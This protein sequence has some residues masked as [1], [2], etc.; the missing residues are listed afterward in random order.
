MLHLQFLVATE[1]I[2]YS[3]LNYTLDFFPATDI[4][5]HFNFAIFAVQGASG[6][7]G[8]AGSPGAD[9]APGERGDQGL[10]GGKG[11]KGFKVWRHLYGKL[12]QSGDVP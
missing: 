2:Y 5:L 11:E 4:L 3:Q 7:R 12:S 10:Q 1:L 9:G 8:P 6:E